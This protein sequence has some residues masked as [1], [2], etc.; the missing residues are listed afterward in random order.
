MRSR[1]RRPGRRTLVVLATSSWRRALPG[2]H[3]LF[4][5]RSGSTSAG[6]FSQALAGAFESRLGGRA[7]EAIAKLDAATGLDLGLPHYFRGTSLARL[8]G[9]AGHAETVVAGTSRSRAAHPPMTRPL[10]STG[11][12]AGGVSSERPRPWHQP[13]NAP[14]A[15]STDG[16]PSARNWSCTP[17]G[18]PDSPRQGETWF[19]VIRTAITRQAITVQTADDRTAD[20][21]TMKTMLAPLGVA[22]IQVDPGLVTAG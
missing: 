19:R 14:C 7:E 6:A 16:A 3:R 21:R 22:R 10:P 11:Q 8:P 18:R 1:R 15:P 17:T 13:P 5:T 4:A 2:G 20:D 9:C 12:T